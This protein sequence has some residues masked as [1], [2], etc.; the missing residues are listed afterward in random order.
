M[1]P[2]V[3]VGL[4]LVAL[5]LVLPLGGGY[6]LSV[7]ADD[8]VGIQPTEGPS[9]PS[10]DQATWR[11]GTDHDC[12][13]RP[14]DLASASQDPGDLVNADPFCGRLVYNREVPD[15]AVQSPRDQDYHTWALPGPASQLSFDVVMTSYVGTYGLETCLPWCADPFGAGMLLYETPHMVAAEIDLTDDEEVVASS[16]A[17]WQ[18]FNLGLRLPS[19]GGVFQGLA[20]EHAADGWAVPIHDVTFVA[21][22]QD[23]VWEPIDDEALVDH[24]RSMQQSG[25]MSWSAIPSVCGYT[26]DGDLSARGRASLGCEVR[27]EWLQEEGETTGRLDGYGG[28][29]QT[30][31]YVCG[32]NTPAWYAQLSCQA[33]TGFCSAPGAHVG[34]PPGEGPVLERGT[35]AGGLIHDRPADSTAGYRVW[36]FV[37]APT[38]SPC[39]G[40][41]EPG[42]RSAQHSPGFPVPYLA[43]DL[44]IYVPAA[45]A[46]GF[47]ATGTVE[48]LARGEGS[49]G[50]EALI[51]VAEGGASVAWREHRAEPNADP[52]ANPLADTT[53]TQVRVDRVLDEDCLA[54]ES[55]VE[56]PDTVDPWI[57][58]IDARA[59][60]DLTAVT[61]QDEARLVDGDLGAYAAAGRSMPPED[62]DASNRPGPA[63]IQLEGTV[64]LFADKDDDGELD[65]LPFS[66]LWPGWDAAGAYPMFWDMWLDESLEVAPDLGC[67][68][69]E[70]GASVAAGTPHGDDWRLPAQ[71]YEQGYGPG[72][73]LLVAVYQSEPSAWEHGATGTM[74]LAPGAD[75]GAVT[76]LM[77]QGLYRLYN[78]TSPA[79]VEVRQQ[80]DTLLEALSSYATDELGDPPP[81]VVIPREQVPGD[82]N[83]MSDF[84]PQCGQ[85]TGGFQ[86]GWTFLHACPGV[87]GCR[88]DT[89]VTAY[90]RDGGPD[91]SP[92]PTRYDWIQPF[93]PGDAD[94]DD[95][96][97]WEGKA[98]WVDVDPLDGDPARSR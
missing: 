48:T 64:G 84:E 97:T 65:R 63:R 91:P 2:S 24:V 30:P 61:L 75:R 70:A 37:V 59:I 8:G 29:C 45:Q 44:D 17:G 32:M 55:T 81:L 40:F 28:K 39:Q 27:F 10:V 71:M 80:V 4:V 56:S 58:V 77:S 5:S 74:V 49:R 89:L 16:D 88:G 60:N 83:G 62:G 21:F 43:H 31:A 52:T 18:R 92:G 78:T 66:R 26:P 67:S 36:H 33:G 85:P 82:P 79:G 14:N 68:L 1:R 25:H 98:L 23:A 11:T 73:G 50:I 15:F 87:A 38:P 51:D 6:H 76:L 12:R 94:S 3:P 47:T 42:F 13:Q 19:T 20:G 22:L 57:D 53:G 95:E 93:V 86:S 34:D 69:T 46:R 90:V 96:R 54:L 9:E 41:V 72:T 35:D 7:G